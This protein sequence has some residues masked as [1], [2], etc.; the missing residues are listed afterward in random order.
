M[1][2]SAIGMGLRTLSGPPHAHRRED[3]G[4]HD[5]QVDIAWRRFP[6][7]LDNALVAGLKGYLPAT[8]G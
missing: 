4:F 2:I 8:F 1:V 3:A 7:R 6:L 5:Q